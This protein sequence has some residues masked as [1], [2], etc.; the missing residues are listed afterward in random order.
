MSKHY[1]PS[2][3]LP[4]ASAPADVHPKERERVAQLIALKKSEN[5]LNV[6]KDIHRRCRTTASEALLLDAYGAR[7]SSLIERRLEREATELMALVRERYPG[8]GGRLREWN[9]AL[10]ARRGDLNPLLEPLNDPS[11][12]PERQAAIAS[13][14]RRDV[15]D[16]RALAECPA[17]GSD[18]PL[19]IAA[20][21]LLRAFEAVTTGPVAEEALA[22]PEISRNSPLAPWKLLVRAIAAYYRNDHALCERCVAAIV[23]DSA[24]S[25]LVPPLRAMLHQ[26]QNLTAAGAALVNQAGGQIDSLRSTLKNLDAAF[27]RRKLDLAQQQIREAVAVC[28]SASPELL[29]RLKQHISIRA[30]LAGV[31]ADKVAAAMGGSSLKEAYFWRLLA[32]AHE[33]DRD[34][35][36]RIAQACGA[37]EE[38]RK[39][40][41]RE[42][43]FP[44]KGPEVAALYLRMADNLN[45]LSP[46]ALNRLQ[47]MFQRN[48]DFYKGEYRDQPAVLRALMPSRGNLSFLSPDLLM[49]RACEADP[50]REN[51]EG[52]MRHARETSPE[53]CDTIA[54]RWAAARRQDIPPLLHLMQSAEDRNAL[55][56]AFKFMERAEAIDGLN[57]EVRRARLR[58]LVSIAVRHLRENKPKLAEKDIRQIEALPQAQQGDRPAFLAALRFVYA[59]SVNAKSDADAAYEK[60]MR[61][62]GDA[63]TTHL[64][65]LQVE[66]WCRRKSSALGAAPPPTLPLHAAYG[67]VCAIGEDMGM[68]VELVAKM[69]EILM[70]ELSQPA[71]SADP[72]FLAALGKA[73][74][75]QN[76]LPLAYVISGA[77]LALGVEARA[78]FLFLRACCLPPWEE[79]RHGACMAAASELARRHHDFDLLTEIGAWRVASMEWF[80]VPGQAGV[81]QD[82]AEI[83]RVVAQEIRARELPVPPP[84]DDDDDDE[85][86]CDCPK[87]QAERLGVPPE[88]VE[89]VQEL[90]PEAAAKAIAEMLGFGGKKKR[91]RRALLDDDDFP[92]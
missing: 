86:F 80:D 91:G 11:L 65:F 25:R 34:G 81:A 29:D 31:R 19:R 45:R 67:R 13:I 1:K 92:F 55:Q 20:A 30:L 74:L 72:R 66:F 35:A 14:V 76:L 23:P 12:P 39:H 9:A 60:A 10:A 75:R 6:A 49:E 88:V 2:G 7:V 69:P 63:I 71:V 17:L 54:E 5:A 52:W 51:F 3:G 4:T 43:W 62:L 70:N 90:G 61:F 58:L 38:F 56:K 59:L 79:K 57:P 48:F 26:R 82:T 24:P 16:L 89:M 21:A 85:G 83:D 77:G 32:R 36:T 33:E 27:D 18:H 37:W 44:A 15:F 87:C 73:A 64:L 28:H 47:Y 84:E 8:A 78:R 68:P 41:I 53:V 46:E 22:L 42:R 50:C 40:A